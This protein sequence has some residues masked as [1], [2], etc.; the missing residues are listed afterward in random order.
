MARNPTKTA[1]TGEPAMT[2]R[3]AHSGAPYRDR[4]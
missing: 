2:I 4:S 1:P 3:G